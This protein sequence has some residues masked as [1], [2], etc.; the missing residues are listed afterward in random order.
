[1]KNYEINFKDSQNKMRYENYVQAIGC[2]WSGETD[3]DV[4]RLIKRGSRQDVTDKVANARY[5]DFYEQAEGC[6]VLSIE[7]IKYLKDYSKELSLERREA[8]RHDYYSFNG[9][10]KSSNNRRVLSRMKLMS[11]CAVCGYK[12]DTSKL[13]FDHIDPAS[14]THKGAG[15]K[16]DWSRP[17]IKQELVKLQVLCDSCHAKKTNEDRKNEQANETKMEI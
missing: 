7:S 12:E 10:S 6:F 16:Y 11:G 15:I 9:K 2:M 1:M 13:H 3:P 14:K 17:R 4:L 5:N 8:Y